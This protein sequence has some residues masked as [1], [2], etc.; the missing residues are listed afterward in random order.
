MITEHT[1]NIPWAYPEH[2]LNIPWT[3][4]K[5]TLNILWTYLEHNLKIAWW[6]AQDLTK[7]QKHYPPTDSLS[8]MDP[9]DDSASRNNLEPWKLLNCADK[10][11]RTLRYHYMWGQTDTR[12]DSIL[13]LCIDC[14]HQL[15]STMITQKK[16]GTLC[17][18]FLPESL[19]LMHSQFTFLDPSHQVSF[20]SSFLQFMHLGF[21]SMF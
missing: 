1:L 7:S 15:W 9:R 17:F 3:Y 8:N 11:K 10:H 13:S 20:W 16:V 19:T 18:S 2:T 14:H 21:V 6:Y 5:H 4:P 12:T